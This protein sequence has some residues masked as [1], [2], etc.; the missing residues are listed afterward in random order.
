M[1]FDAYRR[2]LTDIY[3]SP[4]TGNPLQRDSAGDYVSRLRNLQALLQTDIENATP[5][6]L[7]SVLESLRNNPLVLQSRPPTFAG[8]VAPAI[9]LYADFLELAADQAIASLLRAAERLTTSGDAAQPVAAEKRLKAAVET[10]QTEVQ[11]IVDVRRGQ[12]RFR[13]DLLQY[14]QGRCALTGIDRPE[15]LIASHIKPWHVSSNAERVDPFNGLLLTVHVDALFDRALIS[16][17]KAG[18]TLV[19]DRLS[20]RERTVFGLSP[21]GRAISLTPAHQAYMH[22]HRERFAANA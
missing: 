17:G 2:Y 3:R 15:L 5:T 10:I 16:F 8:D 13:A 11:A 22:H 14:W 4:T 7:R 1:S 9:R 18:E 12:E 21:P 20:V 6:A 19:S